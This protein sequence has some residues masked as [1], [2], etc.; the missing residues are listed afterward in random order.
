MASERRT[1]VLVD[2]GIQWLIIRQAL[3]H[4]LCFSVAASL[5]VVALEEVSGGVFRSP[6]ER[7]QA[8][9]PTITSLYLSLLVLLPVF[10]HDWIK[11]SHRFAGPVTRLRRI[12]RELAEGKVSSPVKFRKG[13]CW[14]E[15]AAELNAAVEALA[16]RKAVQETTPVNSSSR[17]DELTL[18]VT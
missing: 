17:E 9:R 3:L 12:L 18:S 4:W 6:S 11:L 16:K 7:W 8:I 1:T 10:I 2:K 15:M 5:L 14:Q 13:D